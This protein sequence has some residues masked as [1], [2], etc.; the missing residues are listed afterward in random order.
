MAS[1]AVLA[2]ITLVAIALVGALPDEVM[3]GGCVVAV[4][5]EVTA[6]ETGKHPIG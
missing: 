2:G 5:E 6:V 3:P 4:G 1:I